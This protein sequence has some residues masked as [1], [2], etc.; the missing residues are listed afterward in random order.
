MDCTRY[1]YLSTPRD[2]KLGGGKIR[3]FDQT[4]AALERSVFC[5]FLPG[6]TGMGYR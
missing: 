2:P 4:Y 1:E 6:A 5:L 3:H